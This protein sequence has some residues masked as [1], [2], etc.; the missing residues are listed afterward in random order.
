MKE[1][2]YWETFKESFI[3]Y[4][5]NLNV[6]WFWVVSILIAM[7]IAPVV[8]I[9]VGI[10]A[11]T[12]EGAAMIAT[13]I[14]IGI[15]TLIAIFII[16]SMSGALM[17]GAYYDLAR[18]RKLKTA[19]MGKYIS[20]YWKTLF[21]LAVIISLFIIGVLLI[22][23]AILAI[24]IV[25]ILL[26]LPL[27]LLVLIAVFIAVIALVFLHPIVVDKKKKAMQT[28]KIT[29]DYAKNNFSHCFL[30]WGVTVLASIVIGIILAVPTYAVLIPIML[31]AGP[32]S[33]AYDMTSIA[34]NIATRLIY[35][36]V[37]IGFS[38][39]IFRSFLKGIEKIK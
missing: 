19:N 18:G 28:L 23:I 20:G 1:I 24:P 34:F 31:T 29:I 36:L 11:V 8:L 38:I 33:F 10:I 37:S 32:Q 7:L 39:F 12:P 30:T 5:N 13:G 22:M 4:K 35:G 3:I 27:L 17:I 2:K 16:S 9:A 15:I 14:V 26:F 21:G 25:G 6:L